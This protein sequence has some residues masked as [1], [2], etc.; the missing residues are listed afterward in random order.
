[1]AFLLRWCFCSRLN[2]IEEVFDLRTFR[3]LCYV[4]SAN[5][6][7]PYWLTFLIVLNGLSGRSGRLFFAYSFSA[8]HV[9]LVFSFTLPLAFKGIHQ[10]VNV[11]I[12]LLVKH[13]TLHSP[14]IAKLW[15]TRRFIGGF[16]CIIV[17]LGFV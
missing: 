14:G 9:A 7:S 8:K 4:L 13:V 3:C 15:R 12:I 6:G 11:F 2:N 5:V 10:R 1:M 16:G 17:S